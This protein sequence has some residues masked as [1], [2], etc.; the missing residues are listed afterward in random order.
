MDIPEKD[1]E[2]WAECV[3]RLACAGGATDE[4]VAQICFG[5]GMFTGALGLHNGLERDWSRLI[6][7]SSTGNTKKQ[8]LYMKDF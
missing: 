2:I 4:D 1:L 8:L 5:Y 6:K 3:A 7:P